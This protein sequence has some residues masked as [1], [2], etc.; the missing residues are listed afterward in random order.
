[1]LGI[2]KTAIIT[3]STLLS[4]I[5]PQPTYVEGMVGQPMEF[6][7]LVESG[8]EIDEDIES[9]LFRGLVKHNGEGEFV[10]DLAESWEIS[11]DGREYTFK[12]KK[13]LTFQ[14]GSVLT[15]ADVRYT[16]SQ[17]EEFKDVEID[18]VDERTMKFRLN[19]PFAPFLEILET[20]IVP[21]NYY[22]EEHNPLRPV[23]SGDFAVGD[24]EKDKG[25]ESIS[26]ET[27]NPN[28][29]IKKIVFKFYDTHAEMLEAAKLGELQSFGSEA[30][31]GWESF[32]EF[33]APLKGRSYALFFNLD[34]TDILK[35]RDFRRDLARAV[36]KSSLVKF[37]LEER[38][39]AI[40]SPIAA[41][42]A[43]S[44]DVS[45]YDYDPNLNVVH[46]VSLTLTVPATVRHLK[47]ADI[48]KENWST[49]GVAVDIRPVAPDDILGEVI[50]PKDFEVLLF[51]QK[52]GVDPDRYP[53]WHS[54]QT[55]YPGLNLSSYSQMRA[56]RALE[57]GR[58]TMNRDERIEHYANFQRVL[59]A[60]VPAIFLYQPVYTFA[61]S[62]KIKGAEIDSL[63]YPQDRYLNFK[64]W[65]LE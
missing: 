38:G 13:N 17:R 7:P 16:L 1:M 20:G 58:K 48:I 4:T 33:K 9:L 47:A 42:W 3:I 8:N 31:I 22:E 50:K 24:V 19:E 18:V 61:V 14:D 32:K 28:Y 49:I 5:I 21:Q 6:N 62:K 35:D 10:A 40:D 36:N 45:S 29:Q 15:T 43:Q 2:L 57:E 39:V 11:A 54:T 52:V 30:S 12:L 60:D 51:G 64:D 59:T 53:Q 63:F 55:T 65:K 41:T 44:S 26:L 34:G 56:D 23:G 27:H 25:V 46:N 37:A